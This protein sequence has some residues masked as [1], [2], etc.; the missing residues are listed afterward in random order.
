MQISGTVAAA[1]DVHDSLEVTS[2]ARQQPAGPADARGRARCHR[3]GDRRHFLQR[4]T[5]LHDRMLTAGSGGG[6]NSQPFLSN[7]MKWL[8]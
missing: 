3:D 4:Y 1:A 6:Q 2:G 7:L 5:L 8:R